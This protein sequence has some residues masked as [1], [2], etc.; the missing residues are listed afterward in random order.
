MAVRFIFFSIL[1]LS[2]A[3]TSIKQNINFIS[4][5]FQNTVFLVWTRKAMSYS[6]GIARVERILK[7]SRSATENIL[8]QD[9]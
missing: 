7:C 4:I 5:A 3:S 6:D 9:E 1:F 2:E 8:S